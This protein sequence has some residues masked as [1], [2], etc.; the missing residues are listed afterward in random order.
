M[1]G[2]LTSSRPRCTERRWQR[3]KLLRERRGEP[4]YGIAPALGTAASISWA[5]SSDDDRRRFGQ[6]AG[7]I[8]SLTLGVAEC[9]CADWFAASRHGSDFR[10]VTH[11]NGVGI[12]VAP[13]DHSLLFAVGAWPPHDG[14]RRTRRPNLS[15]DLRGSAT[16][17]FRTPQR[18]R[19]ANRPHGNDIGSAFSGGNC[20]LSQQAATAAV[21]ACLPERNSDLSTHMRCRMTASLRVTATQARAMPRR[22]ATCIPQARSADHFV[23][24]KHAE[25]AAKWDCYRPRA[26]AYGAL[27]EIEN[28]IHAFHPPG[29]FTTANSR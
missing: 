15:R 12:D 20:N 10:Y 5:R 25:S 8:A 26:T 18:D 24:Q 11:C 28:V 1:A 7:T 17:R 19:L 29:R 21:A 4:D 22:L 14:V 9:V 23:R 3:L 16:L 27:G 6:A 2:S 13:M